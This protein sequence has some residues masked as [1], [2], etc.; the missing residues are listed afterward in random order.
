MRP[1]TPVRDETSQTPSALSKFGDE[2]GFVS[3]GWI[4][5][6]VLYARFSGGLSAEVGNACV[7]FVRG[8]LDDVESLSYFI[9]S[10]KLT[11]YDLLA[12]SA[13]VRLVLANRKKFTSLAI[14]IWPAGKSPATAA[15]NAALGEPTEILTDPVDFDR[16]LRAAAPFSRTPLEL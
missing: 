5:N 12:R 10:R 9:D 15:F 2:S 11:H 8:L 14:L 4:A 3:V 6:R 16:R 1:N 13:F 7:Q